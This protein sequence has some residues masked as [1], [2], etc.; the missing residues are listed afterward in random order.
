MLHSTY[1]VE[2]LSIDYLIPTEPVP[3]AMPSNH[4]I[5]VGQEIVEFGGGFLLLVI[6][7]LFGAK[8]ANRIYNK[9]PPIKIVPPNYNTFQPHIPKVAVRTIDFHTIKNIRR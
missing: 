4:W 3:T 9:H 1:G 6:I 7:I 8:I 5:G 2:I